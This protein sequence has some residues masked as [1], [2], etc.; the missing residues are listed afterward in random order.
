MSFPSNRFTLRIAS[1]KLLIKLAY[2]IGPGIISGGPPWV[3][4]QLYSINAKVEGNTL[5]T[6]KQMRPLLQ[7]LLADRFHLKVHPVQKIVPGYALVIAQGGPKLQL[8]KGG[9]FLGM[10]GRYGDSELKYQNDSVVDFANVIGYSAFRKPV[11][12][13]TG[14]EGMYDFD[15]KFSP[16]DGP[17]RD[18]PRYSSLPD[19]FTAVQSQL[20]LKLVPQR[21]PVDSLVIDHVEP[22]SEN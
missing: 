17:L 18:D 10:G 19:I 2:G 5:L 22:L 21:V 1:L 12:D 3:D 13:R 14:L 4:S 11:V 6:Q 7:N 16:E 8:T 20:G 15:L 9:P